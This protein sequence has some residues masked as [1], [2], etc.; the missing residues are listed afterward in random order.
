MTNKYLKT[1]SSLATKGKQ[2]KTTLRFH[3]NS[4]RMFKSK[5]TKQKKIWRREPQFTTEINVNKNSHS[6]NQYGEFSKN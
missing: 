6:G 5:T 1:C 4:V 3:V 2:M